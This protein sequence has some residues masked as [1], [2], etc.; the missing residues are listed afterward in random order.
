MLLAALLAGSPAAQACGYHDP[1]RVNLGML[2]LAYPDALY[3]R[4]AVWTAQLEGA[5]PRDEQPAAADPQSATIRAM[6]RLRE[7]VVRLGA[8]RDRIGTA[9]EGRSVPSF[10]MVLIGP[11]LWTRFEPAGATLEMAAH[12]AGPASDD[13]VIVTDE[14]VVAAL[15]DGRMPPREA[16]ELGL[17]RFYGAEG[18]VKDVA[19]VLD[20][21][22]MTNTASTAG[23]ARA[24]SPRRP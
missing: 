9:L 21:L 13:V 14:P 10:S 23:V 4:T 1:S 12:A 5:I 8:L 19:S 15:L 3:V 22:A 20:R 24:T 17:M 11:M 7:T 2:N 16:R 18:R 6:F